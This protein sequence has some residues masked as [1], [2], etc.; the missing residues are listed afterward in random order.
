[1]IQ[2]HHLGAYPKIENR[3]LKRYSHIHIYCNIIHIVKIWE[4]S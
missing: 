4:A 3:I 1:M 2:Q